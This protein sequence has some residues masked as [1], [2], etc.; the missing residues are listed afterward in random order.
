MGKL[1]LH[2]SKLPSFDRH[3]LPHPLIT[4]ISYFVQHTY[5]Q[6]SLSQECCNRAG[7]IVFI[8]Q[9]VFSCRGSGGLD[10]RAGLGC[11]IHGKM[12]PPIR[13][14]T[15]YLMIGTIKTPS[16][17]NIF[18]GNFSK[19]KFRQIFFFSENHLSFFKNDLLPI[20]ILSHL[21]VFMGSNHVPCIFEY[22]KLTGQFFWLDGARWRM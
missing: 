20:I 10:R 21:H 15:Q 14:H 3:A 16:L 11:H 6:I 2:A 19:T 5:I 8:R 1:I 18:C 22:V 9:T 7:V 12:T 4:S 17:F 13:Y